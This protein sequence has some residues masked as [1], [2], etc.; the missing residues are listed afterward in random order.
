[1]NSTPYLKLLPLLATVTGLSL[2]PVSGQPA[3]LAPVTVTGAAIATIP[4]ADSSAATVVSG[5]E[6][7][8]GE[9]T[10]TRDLSAQTPNL[11]V[12]DANNERTPKFSIRGYRENNFGQGSPVIGLYVDDVPYFD[13]NS[14]GLALFD[15]REI[16]FVRGDQGTLYGASGVGGIINVV[17][18]QPGN[19]THGY[20]EASY[21]NYNSQNYQLGLGGPLVTNKLFFS[22]DGVYALR[23]GYVYNSYLHD[24]PD[25]Q[26]TLDG[27]ATLRWTP[28]APWDIALS[29]NAGRDNDEFVPTYHPG[30]TSTTVVPAPYNGPDANPFSV[31]RGYNG[32]ADTQNL[33]QALKIAY[34][35]PSMKF[36]SVATHREWRQDLAQDFDFA[37]LPPAIPTLEGFTAPK[38]DQWTEEMRLESPAGADKLKWRAGL[39]YLNGDLKNYSGSLAGPFVDGTASD[40]QSQTYALFGQA[41]YTVWNKLD[42][43]AGV[44]LTYDYREMQ[45]THIN[46]LPP[47]EG[48]G[49][50]SANLSDEFTDAQPKFA[51]AWHFTPTLQAYASATAGYQSGG[52][53]PSVDT[54][55]QS[56]Y[57]P[58]R[59]WQFELGAKSSWWEDK[60]S[61]NADLFYTESDKYQTYQIN[62]TDPE[63]AYL[64]N[65]H[66]AELYG[67]ELELTARPIRDL[68]LSAGLGYTD[69]HYVRFT[70]PAD[71]SLTGAPLDLN[72][73]PISFVP[74]F[75]ANLS[76]RYRLPWHHLYVH[77]EVIGVGRNHLDD[78]STV[79]SGP[80]VQNTYFL[81]NAQAGWENKHFNIYFFARNIFDRHYFNNALNLGPAYGSLILQPGDPATYGVAG[82]ARF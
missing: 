53:N 1:M 26:D 56:E 54:P 30:V 71:A 19:Q 25:S 43:T 21:G 22:V 35:A 63:E 61:A 9:I 74:E 62:P 28:S 64:L 72:D 39:F 7:Q 47:A 45:R 57:S 24:H 32:Y 14:R 68:D 29:A 52:F 42:L 67:A 77:G 8:V 81:A 17:T 33:D 73:K 59:D 15:A 44:R 37:A 20:A 41:T 58:E 12:F 49:T 4:Q 75:T 10:A 46:P 48:G 34:D 69:A 27:R 66:R 36:T 40:S 70:E 60:L 55:S 18:R 6:V 78:T 13:M 76:A 38:L 51:L 2:L 65:A 31:S 3:Q 23:D 5:Q 79:V 82:T 50:F 11:S 80:V 16:E